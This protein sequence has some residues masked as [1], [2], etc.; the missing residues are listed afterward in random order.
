MLQEDETQAKHPWS[1]LPAVHQRAAFRTI[2]RRV[3]QD[4]EY[5]KLFHHF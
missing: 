5:I 1:L 4:R 3:A 2:E